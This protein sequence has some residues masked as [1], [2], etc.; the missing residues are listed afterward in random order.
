MRAPAR[1]INPIQHY[2]WG[3]HTA[4]ARLQGREPSERP[5]AELWMG[6]HPAAP[7]HVDV[8]GKQFSLL[9]VIE[10]APEEVLGPAV[11]A[12]FGPRLPYLLKV[13]AADKP[14]SL[15]AHPTQA[16]AEQGF[17]AEE[18]RGVPIDAP[19]RNYRDASA[20]PELLCALSP[21][22]ALCGFRDTAATI[23]LLERLRVQRLQ[24]L[25]DTLRS[26]PPEVAMPAVVER[27]LTWPLHDRSALV[28]EVA[29]AAEKLYAD[30]GEFAAEAAWTL[31]LAELHPED[32]G[33]VAALLLN[34]IRLEP[35]EALYLPSGN[36]HAYLGGFGVEIM[37][38]S[39]NVLRGGLTPKHVDVPELQRVL[40]HSAGP[41]ALVLPQLVSEH[42]V[43]YPTTAPDFE[44]TRFELLDGRG[45]SVDGHGPQVLLCV[46]GT[47]GLRHADGQVDLGAGSSVFVPAA[48]AE[49]EMSGTGAVFRAV[50]PGYAFSG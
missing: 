16:Q 25:V 49:V 12:K 30:R 35:G 34:L 31:R 27:T 1:M 33:V 4:I 19:E 5:E 40:D 42:E 9:E 32:P 3:S 36:L 2:A 39:D 41:I 50:V 22:D 10:R 14:L 44:L 46:A 47:V 24:A 38:N 21:V 23:E 29:A 18:A 45:V 6:A 8:G 7:S 48:A 15:Q 13:L 28:A 17:H 20:K 37:A 11:T 26:D 43:V